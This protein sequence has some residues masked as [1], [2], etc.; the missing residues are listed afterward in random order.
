MIP[1]IKILFSTGAFSG[2]DQISYTFVVI[3]PFLF[4]IQILFG[5][6]Y[7][8]RLKLIVKKLVINSTMV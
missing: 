8:L 3:F 6:Y 4:R 1:C 7:I 5:I 2:D